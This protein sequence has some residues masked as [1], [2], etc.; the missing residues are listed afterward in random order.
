M[1]KIHFTNK[2]VEDLSEIWRYTLEAWSENQADFYYQML[3]DNCNEIARNP[4]LGK[5]YDEIAA[6]LLGIQAGKHIIFY[7]RLRVNEVEIIRILHE[8]MDLKNRAAI[9]SP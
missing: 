5:K 3:L 4:Q 7:R 1:T 9:P 2:A 8:R 6:N